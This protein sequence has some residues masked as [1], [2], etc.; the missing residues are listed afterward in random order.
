LPQSG[1]LP[2]HNLC[3]KAI[4]G[5][6][7]AV[8]WKKDLEVNE[9]VFAKPL[10]YTPRECTNEQVV[11]V[12]SL[13]IVRVIDG[14]TGNLLRSRTLNPPFQAVDAK[15]TEAGSTVGITGTPIIDA[16]TGVLYLYS[17]GYKGG[18]LGS[19]F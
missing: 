19:L 2:S 17:K 15:C 18:L 16:K 14:L 9:T 8:S 11:I 1:Y 6:N 12:S 5:G 13:N 4:T 10:V 3:P 7:F